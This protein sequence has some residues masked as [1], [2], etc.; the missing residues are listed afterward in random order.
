MI[1]K[2]TKY[3]DFTQEAKYFF[4]GAIVTILVVVIVV[5]IIAT[6]FLTGYS[7]LK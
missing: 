5:G 1:F 6:L 2:K 7:I 4:G 3:K